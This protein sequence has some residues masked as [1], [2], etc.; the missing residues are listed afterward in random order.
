MEPLMGTNCE[1]TQSFLQLPETLAE[2]RTQ[3]V[4]MGLSFVNQLLM[5]G[6]S[7]VA[8]G[9]HSGGWMPSRAVVMELSCPSAPSPGDTVSSMPMPLSRSMG[10]KRVLSKAPPSVSPGIRMNSYEVLPLSMDRKTLLQCESLEPAQPE[11]A[12]SRVPDA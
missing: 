4:D 8:W 9:L 6:Q 12:G 5:K 1:E 3:L 7:L 10:Y 11:G 2:L